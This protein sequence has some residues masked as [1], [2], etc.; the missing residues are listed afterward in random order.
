[1]EDHASLVRRDDLNTLKGSSRAYRAEKVLNIDKD[2]MNKEERNL[3]VAIRMHGEWSGTRGGGSEK[4]KKKINDFFA[5]ESG[6]CWSFN[7]LL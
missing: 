4:R 1:M 6:V 5:G 3:I 2:R 7:A